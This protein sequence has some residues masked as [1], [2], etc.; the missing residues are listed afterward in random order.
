MNTFY[1]NTDHNGEKS[2]HTFHSEK[3]ARGYLKAMY[4]EK[5]WSLENN[6]ERYEITGKAITGTEYRISVKDYGRYYY[7]KRAADIKNVLYIGRLGRQ[8]KAGLG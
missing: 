1:I 5:L 8:I 4:H 3:Y 6:P 2:R 7:L